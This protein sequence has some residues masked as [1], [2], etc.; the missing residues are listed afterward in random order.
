MDTNLFE[1]ILSDSYI[2]NQAEKRILALKNYILGG[3]FIDSKEKKL[4]EAATDNPKLDLWINSID[5]KVLSKITPQN[6]YSTFEVLEKEIKAIEP[7][8]LYLPYELP[9]EEVAQIGTK[10][11]ADYGKKFLMEI[12]ID[13][14]LIAGCALSFRGIYKDYSVKQKITDNKQEI[15]AA[16]R[17]YVKH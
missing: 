10:L 11:R 17:Q 1:L 6:I 16:F 14:S 12:T 5:K 3:I 9:D 4:K 2:K 8:I 7:L 15:L 13:P